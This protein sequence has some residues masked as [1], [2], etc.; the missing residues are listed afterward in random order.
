MGERATVCAFLQ[1]AD[2]GSCSSAAAAA[3]AQWPQDLSVSGSGVWSLVSSFMCVFA[4]T[5]THIHTHTHPFNALQRSRHAHFTRSAPMAHHHNIFSP[6][7][8]VFI[9]LFHKTHSHTHT[10]TRVHMH[11]FSISLSSSL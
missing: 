10:P 6:H 8:V 5:N 3:L 11:S 2:V 7:S 4:R 1:A 9:M